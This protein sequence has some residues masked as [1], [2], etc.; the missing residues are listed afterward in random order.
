MSKIS[1]KREKQIERFKMLTKDVPDEKV[2]EILADAYKDF[3]TF[4][5]AVRAFMTDEQW[6]QYATVMNERFD[7]GRA[8]YFKDMATDF[9]STPIFNK[10]RKRLSNGLEAILHG[11]SSIIG[12]KDVL[13]RNDNGEVS[14]VIGEDNKFK[15][16]DEEIVYTAYL[17]DSLING[18]ELTIVS[19]NS[20]EKIETGYLV[21]CLGNGYFVALDPNKI[22]MGQ[23]SDGE[24]K[25]IPGDFANVLP[26]S[27]RPVSATATFFNFSTEFVDKHK[28]TI[29][30]FLFDL[31]STGSDHRMMVT[32]VNGEGGSEN[33]YF[34]RFKTGEFCG[35]RRDEV[36]F[37]KKVLQALLSA[38]SLIVYSYATKEFFTVHTKENHERMT[39]EEDIELH[40]ATLY[41]VALGDE[42]FR[43]MPA[44]QLK[45]SYEHD[46][47]EGH[48]FI[49][50]I[51]TNTYG[52][53]TDLRKIVDLSSYKKHRLH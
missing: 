25:N 27:A 12:N 30:G 18:G 35:G 7:K 53:W 45:W 13:I 9:Q 37:R 17:M 4:P 22:D 41:S 5:K 44:E 32:T 3:D 11:I 46:S 16:K 40:K 38:G 24:Y 2:G 19:V 42:R 52:N 20:D 51:P 43:Y 47:G 48:K 6:K 29:D 33:L 14:F 34:N 10:E 28:S 39:K 15:S 8:I 50:E 31:L 36:L 26:E 23:L 1:D 21:K 49:G